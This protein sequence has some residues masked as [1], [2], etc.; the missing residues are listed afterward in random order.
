M[1]DM[2]LNNYR[3]SNSGLQLLHTKNWLQQL[4]SIIWFSNHQIL[5]GLA[6]QDYK[7]SS[8]LPHGTNGVH[9]TF[10]NCIYS[11]HLFACRARSS[12]SK[13]TVSMTH[14]HWLVRERDWRVDDSMQLKI[15]AEQHYHQLCWQHDRADH[16]SAQLHSQQVDNYWP[17]MHLQRSSISSVVSD[18]WISSRL[19]ISTHFETAQIRVIIISNF[20]FSLKQT[21]LRQNNHNFW[22][23][24]QY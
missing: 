23:P 8:C 9:R 3:G 5:K 10:V 12:A 22:L 24:V 2:L 11:G 19:P 6:M 21:D 18:P 13:Q 14:M 4:S 1:C 15:S 16:S 17:C 7:Y 20:R